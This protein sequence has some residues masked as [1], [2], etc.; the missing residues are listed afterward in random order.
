MWAL[1]VKG[2]VFGT[3]PCPSKDDSRASKA[4][5]RTGAQSI[6]AKA[7]MAAIGQYCSVAY[8]SPSHRLFSLRHA[9]PGYV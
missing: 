9:F 4:Q 7:M 8:S 5:E 1:G 2:M 6:R 3:A